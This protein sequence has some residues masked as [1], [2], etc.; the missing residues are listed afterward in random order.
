[1]VSLAGRLGATSPRID[2]FFLAEDKEIRRRGVTE[3]LAEAK[4]QAEAIARA[5]GVKRG[6]VINVSNLSLN[7]PGPYDEIVTTAMR[8]S[9]P[10]PPQSPPPVAIPRERNAGESTGGLRDRTLPVRHLYR[11]R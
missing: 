1:M 5:S 2:R 10:P 11:D 9:A 3:A 8:V 7:G 6:G 4:L